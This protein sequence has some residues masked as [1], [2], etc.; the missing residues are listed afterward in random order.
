M[1]P[2]QRH[3]ARELPVAEV[4]DDSDVASIRCPNPEGHAAVVGHGAHSRVPRRSSSRV[5]GAPQRGRTGPGRHK[6]SPYVAA[7]RA[8]VC[9]GVT[10]RRQ[11]RPTSRRSLRRHSSAPV[12]SLKVKTWMPVTSGAAAG[13][14]A[15]RTKGPSCR[16][17]RRSCPI[18]RA[19]T[20][21]G[22]RARGR[23]CILPHGRSRTR[24]RSPGCRHGWPC[25]R[26]TRPF[27]GPEPL[28]TVADPARHLPAVGVDGELPHRRRCNIPLER[29]TLIDQLRPLGQPGLLGIAHTVHPARW[30]C[31]S[32]L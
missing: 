3:F 16:R 29:P 6:D 31:W 8:A 4:A 12:N 14:A 2:R 10:R 22:G 9:R 5:R 20:W 27:R 11:P 19:P 18:P 25:P 15:D 13:W 30:R 24:G 7:R 23:V 32:R 21:P 28:E 26:H 17:A 1:I